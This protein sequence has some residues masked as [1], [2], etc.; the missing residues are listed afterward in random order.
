MLST[1]N[2]TMQFGAK[3]LFEQVTAKFSDGNRY[4][5][6]GSQRLRQIDAHE[7]PERRARAKRG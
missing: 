1:F 3:P 6:I 2:V 5:L 7:D 4:G